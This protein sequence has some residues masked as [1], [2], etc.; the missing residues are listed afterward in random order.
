V[1]GFLGKDKKIERPCYVKKTAAINCEVRAHFTDNCRDTQFIT[2]I[3]K[4]NISE[5]EEVLP[6]VFTPNGDGQNDSFYIKIA[7][8][9]NF[10]LWI[11]NTRGVVVFET[12]NIGKNGVG[13]SMVKHVN[14]ERIPG[15]LSGTI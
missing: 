5:S 11:V 9:R 15:T 4:P 12:K 13:I 1:D 14:L 7:T 8:P 6:T 2:E 10:H 3:I